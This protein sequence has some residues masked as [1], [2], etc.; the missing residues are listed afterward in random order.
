MYIH[1]YLE[2]IDYRYNFFYIS[3]NS[4]YFIN[5]FL[6]TKLQ[7]SKECEFSHAD[8]YLYFYHYRLCT[9]FG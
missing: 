2:V 1:T 6:Q 3:Y 9:R 7:T 8:Y 4:Y 5:I